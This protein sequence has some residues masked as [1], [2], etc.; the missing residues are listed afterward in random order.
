MLQ[1]LHEREAAFWA[2]VKGLG[3]P[4]VKAEAWGSEGIPCLL[5][6]VTEQHVCTYNA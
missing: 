2:G 4:M 3:F 6:T 5:N 1:G